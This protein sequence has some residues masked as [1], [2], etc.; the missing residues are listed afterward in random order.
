MRAVLVAGSTRREIQT[1]T[2]VI[3][4][5]P[6]ATFVVEGAAPLHAVLDAAVD[7]FFLLDLAGDTRVN[8]A[9]IRRCELSFGD[10]IE[11]GSVRLELVKPAP[12][13]PVAQKPAFVGAAT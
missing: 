12:P 5:G 13:K 9:A 8:G 3:G 10:V 1:G 6:G 2:V 11:L 7:G 4:S